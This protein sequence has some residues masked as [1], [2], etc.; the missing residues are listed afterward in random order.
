MSSATAE[1][2]EI[3]EEKNLDLRTSAYVLA[4]TRLNDYYTTRGL[5][6]WSYY[7]YAATALYIWC[8]YILVHLL[9][10]N[11]ILIIIESTQKI[12]SYNNGL[13][14]SVDCYELKDQLW[15][16]ELYPQRELSSKTIK[17]FIQSF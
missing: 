12:H 13:L 3:A 7:Y 14:N 11:N 5:E 2:I 15:Y 17:D 4:I 8:F 9:F 6:I 1:V 10:I 16:L